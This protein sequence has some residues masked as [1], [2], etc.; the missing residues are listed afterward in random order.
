MT[1]TDTT[2][3]A[4]PIDWRAYDQFNS[5]HADRRWEYPARAGENAPLPWSEAYGGQYHV[6]R[7]EDLRFVTEHPEFFSS[8]V[9]SCTNEY[10]I[11]LPPLDADPPLQQEFR[12]ILNPY[13]S[14]SYLMRYADRIRQI[15]ND[16]IDGWID[17]GS[18]C[19][20]P[21]G[22]A[23]SAGCHPPVELISEFAMPFSS[24]VLA[25]VVFDETDPERVRRARDATT[26]IAVKGDVESYFG[27]A[28]V[29]AEYLA[30]R[31]DSTDDRDDI[32]GALVR[33]DLL[34]RPLDE[35]ER[36]GV[37]TV[38]FL[39]GLDT[40]RGAIGTIGARL[41]TMPGLEQRM[42]EPGWAK[43]DLD[44]ILRVQAPVA[45]MAR[46][47]IADVQLG[48]RQL[49]KGDRLVLHFDLANRDE[50]RF[51]A[52]HEIRLDDRR[53]SNALFGLGIHRCV[54]SNLARLQLEI[55]FEE[56][57]KRVTDLRLP[58]GMTFED[59]RYAPGAALGPEELPLHF[60]RR[61]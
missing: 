6:V 31:E 49:K 33:G 48:G 42:R 24:G 56:L 2:A 16:A 19:S 54:G 46:T 52:A 27:L 28:M 3:A 30:G 44:E 18:P 60:R 39:G 45:C 14:R 38:L 59:I 23:C 55:G 40:T 9:P 21:A 35:N 7:Y 58:E 36:L 15:A 11:R 51:E 12:R 57:L 26:A 53:P 41:A 8:A 43:R 1:E 29:A 32:L 37:V 10:G 61:T 20:H 22:S 34:G 47:A 13:L 25:T 5:E 4:C 50:S 17:K